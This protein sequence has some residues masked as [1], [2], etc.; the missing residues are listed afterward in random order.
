[1]KK[2]NKS[3][4]VKIITLK[5]VKCI[6]LVFIMILIIYGIVFNVN[7]IFFKK[8][9]LNIGSITFL[10]EEDDESMKPSIKNSDFLI[11]SKSKNMNLEDGDVI[12]YNFNGK[13]Y[14]Q[15]VCNVINENGKRYYI[16]RGDNNLNNNIEEIRENDIIGELKLK[17]PFLGFIVKIFQNKYFFLFLI[18][19]I[20]YELIYI[21]RR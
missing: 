11:V 4:K 16:T 20:I 7:M 8:D 13:V 2:I 14:I 5:T 21:K 1:M 17:I 12:A 15:R 3:K 18:I 6:F 9:Y 19:G 10:I